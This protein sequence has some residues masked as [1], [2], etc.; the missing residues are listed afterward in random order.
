MP[1]IQDIKSRA[2]E[3]D[4]PLRELGSWSGIVYSR[5][6]DAFKGW[7]T[8]R[9]KEMVALESAVNAA[10]RERAEKFNKMAA[11]SPAAVTT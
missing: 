9:D 8:L 3:A 5:V 2:Q 1:N 7:V 10:I 6:C 4:I 11:G